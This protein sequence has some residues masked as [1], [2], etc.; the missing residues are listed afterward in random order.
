MTTDSNGGYA[1]LDENT[2][3]SVRIISGI[4]FD[5]KGRPTPTAVGRYCVWDYSDDFDA[6][7]SDNFASFV[8]FRNQ[9]NYTCEKSTSPIK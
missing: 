2:R 8:Q 3:K 4:S 5:K 9:L 7:K 6:R 1:Q